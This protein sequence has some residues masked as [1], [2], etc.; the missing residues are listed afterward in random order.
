MP[1]PCY[2]L[3]NEVN[4]STILLCIPNASLATLILAFSVF[5]ISSVLWHLLC[6]CIFCL[7]IA[8]QVSKRSQLYQQ[9]CI[10]YF[11]QRGPL[12]NVDEGGYLLI[13]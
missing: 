9:W 13:C 7:D 2:Q 1:C 10:N 12:S 3:K 5:V 4:A 11:Y 8:Q 6:H